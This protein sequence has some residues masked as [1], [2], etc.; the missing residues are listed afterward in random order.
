MYCN[1][2]GTP[3]LRRTS[4]LIEEQDQIEYV[5]DKAGTLTRKGSRCC[6]IASCRVRGYCRRG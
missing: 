4:I 5:S 1:K 2:T 3:T 6:S